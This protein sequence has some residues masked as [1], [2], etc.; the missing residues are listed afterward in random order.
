[1]YRGIVEALHQRGSGPLVTTENEPASAGRA[2]SSASEAESEA[3]EP[4][5]PG[6][7]SVLASRE[8]AIESG[9]LVDVT[10]EA[11]SLGLPLPVGL[12]KPLWDVAITASQELPEEQQDL[13]LRDI[14][15]ALRLRLSTSQPKLPLFEFPVLLA[16]PP[17][18]I[19]KLCSLLALVH[20]DAASQQAITLVLR[21]EVS[22]LV[23]PLQN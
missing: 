22:T 1:V 5:E 6:L 16:F 10:E 12:T 4:A 2:A 15:L 21:E 14:L 17:E 18:P 3:Q 11:Q 20:A 19:P 7:S 9:F 23:S 13:R 8:K